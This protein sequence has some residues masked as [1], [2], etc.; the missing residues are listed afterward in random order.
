ME[1]ARLAREYR[2]GFDE[3]QDIVREVEKP[4]EVVDGIDHPKK[5]LDALA[6]LREGC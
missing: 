1:G 2:G 5:R 3:L 4:A 6:E